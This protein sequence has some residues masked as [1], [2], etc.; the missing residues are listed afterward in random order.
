MYRH[1]IPAL[2][3]VWCVYWL[4]ASAWAKPAA[5]RESLRSRLS[6]LIPLAVGV[7]LFVRPPLLH[8]RFLPDWLGWYWLGVVLVAAGLG[9][10]AYA[11]V[12]LGRNW[13]GVVTLKQDHTLITTGP[14]RW[15]RHPIYSGLLLALLGSAL[16]LGE[17]RDLVG[18]ALVTA[19]FVRKL[20]IEEQFLAG[21]FP[22]EYRRYRSQVAALVPK[23][24]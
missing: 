11:R 3:G 15:T 16:A 9:W 12:H 1:L 6:H 22:A 20:A 5:R 8:Q 19:S 23:L 14:Y 7:W 24:F 13:S 18:F 17:L 21:Q 2:W 10:A 4:V